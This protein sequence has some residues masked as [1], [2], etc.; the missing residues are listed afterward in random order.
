MELEYIKT[1]NTIALAVVGWIVGHHINSLRDVRLKKR[2]TT[3]QYLID[4]YR[5]LTHEINQRELTDDR[6]NKLENLIADI[7][8]FGSAEQINLVKNITDE[9]VCG[10]DEFNLDL[11][12]NSLRN[13]LRKQL[14]LAKV[15][16]NVRWLRFNISRDS[17]RKDFKNASSIYPI[18]IIR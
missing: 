11:L 3:T 7:Q 5:T 16:G 15:D 8:L 4:T 17:S 13:D 6:R 9:I 2:E 1:G 12:L 18:S 14:K 10:R